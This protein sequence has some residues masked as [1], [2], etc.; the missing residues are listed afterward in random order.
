MAK[1]I[2]LDQGHEPKIDNGACYKDLQEAV[3]TR[4]IGN[5]V[6]SLSATQPLFQVKR[7][8]SV[9]GIR[10][11][12]PNLNRKIKWI[13]QNSKTTDLLISI[14]INAGGGTGIESWGYAGLPKSCM[15]FYKAIHNEVVKATGLKDRGIKDE[16]NNKHGQLGII[17]NTRPIAILVE[18]GFIDKDYVW[19]KDEKNLYKVAQGIINGINQY[20]KINK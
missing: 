16:K 14:H 3:L 10:L 9:G 17:H 7:V 8:P 15:P 4:L 20:L 11:I 13:N 6:V 18:C 2:V 19:L 5:Y 12:S 1:R